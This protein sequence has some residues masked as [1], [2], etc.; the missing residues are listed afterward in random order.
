MGNQIRCNFCLYIYIYIWFFCMSVWKWSHRVAVKYMSTVLFSLLSNVLKIKIYLYYSFVSLS[1]AGPDQSGSIREEGRFGRRDCLLQRRAG[2]GHCPPNQKRHGQP[3][4]GPWPSSITTPT[5]KLICL[6]FL[7][8]TYYSS[9]LKH[10]LPPKHSALLR[11]SKDMGIHDVSKCS[12][13]EVQQTRL[14]GKC[15]SSLLIFSNPG[16][17]R[18]KKELR[19][20]IEIG[21]M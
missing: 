15:L 14:P 12:Q 8:Y 10:F 1:K 16:N 2:R 20:V 11:G 13:G 3:Q 7:T 19:K 4:A 9:G 5:E 17:A 18:G 6:M 21:S